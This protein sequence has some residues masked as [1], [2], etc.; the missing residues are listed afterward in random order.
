MANAMKTMKTMKTRKTINAMKTM[1]TMKL[2]H[3]LLKAA[4]AEA[5]Q[6]ARFQLLDEKS[7]R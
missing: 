1:K 7:T 3:L 6:Q 4:G 2:Q 5:E